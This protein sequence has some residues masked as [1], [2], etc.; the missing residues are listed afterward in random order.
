MSWWLWVNFKIC[1]IL[2]KKTRI[3]GLQAN[4]VS[5]SPL[6]PNL[7]MLQEWKWSCW[8]WLINLNSVRTSELVYAWGITRQAEGGVGATARGVRGKSYLASFS[9]SRLAKADQPSP[10]GGRKPEF[11]S[12]TGARAQQGCKNRLQLV[13]VTTW[14]RWQPS[15]NTSSQGNRK[16]AQM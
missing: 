13:L 10:P 2:T 4:T 8:T 14:E 3:I 12:S 15:V 7:E 6:E 1:N 9:L 16:T 11:Q 5:G